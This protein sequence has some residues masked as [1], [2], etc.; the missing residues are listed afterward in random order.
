MLFLLYPGI[1]DNVVP[2]F[3]SSK[4]QQIYHCVCDEDVTKDNP[5][6]IVTKEEILEDMHNRAAVCD[7]HPMKQKIIVS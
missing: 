5:F 6:K 7:F 2:I 3:L 1:P 4:T